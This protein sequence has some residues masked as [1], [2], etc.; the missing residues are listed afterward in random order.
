VA[1]A[2]SEFFCVEVI[3]ESQVIEAAS[4]RRAFSGCRQR[5]KHSGHVVVKGIEDWKRRQA[6]MGFFWL[7][8]FYL[9]AS[10]HRNW[11]ARDVGG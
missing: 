8:G 11:P 9:A 7:F 6:P 2:V 4:S 5:R 3:F 10:A 1:G